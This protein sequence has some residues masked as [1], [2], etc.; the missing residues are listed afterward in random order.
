MTDQTATILFNRIKIRFVL[1]RFLEVLLFAIGL[2]LLVYGAS[3][4]T[5]FS[6]TVRVISSVVAGILFL[7]G[8]VWIKNLFRIDRKSIVQYVSLHYPEL[9]F[10]TDLLIIDDSKLNRL[11]RLQ[12]ERTK[13]TFENIVKSIRVPYSFMRP[14]F[15]VL[16][17]GL[18]AFLLSGI[19][20]KT[21]DQKSTSSIVTDRKADKLPP[22][23][24]D[25]EVTITA[26]AYMQVKRTTQQEPGLQIQEGSNVRWTFNFS[27]SVKA[28]YLIF[29]GSDS[30]SLKKTGGLYTFTK[31]FF[32]SGFY[33][34]GWMNQD[35]NVLTSDYFRIDVQQDAAPII[36]ITN[37]PQF[38]EVEQDDD[39]R[40]NVTTLLKDDW[41]IQDAHIIA[42]ISKG[43]GES[44][45]F[46]E[47]RLV[48]TKPK[49]FSGKNIE[50]SLQ[51]DL[52]KM[53]MEPGDE[54]YFYVVGFDNKQP[55]ANRTRTETHFIVLADTAKIEWAMDDGL[56]V[57]LM[58]EYF[59]SQRQIIIDT[60]KLLREKKAITKQE[61]N[62]RSNEL[63]YDQ[64]L[65]R[66]K[67]GEF[68]GEEFESGIAHE[69]EHHEGEDDHDHDDPLAEYSHKH[70][71]E[72]EHQEVALPDKKEGEKED[73]LAAF[74]HAHDDSETATF[75]EQSIR[76]KLKAALAVMWD[77]ELYL[78]L[79]EPDKSL[80]FQ[81]KALKLLKEISNASRIYVHKVGFDPPPVKEE[82][83]LTG[84]LKDILSMTTKWDTSKKSKFPYTRQA[85]QS[86]E[87][88][89]TENRS[90]VLKE[91]RFIFQN[92]GNEVAPTLLEK[93][94]APLETLTLLKNLSDGTIPQDE[95]TKSLRI[96]RKNL[97]QLLPAESE[98]V[99]M[100]P[101]VVHPLE[102]SF[103]EAIGKSK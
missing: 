78:R 54:L 53:G 34:I 16:I 89:L 36:E 20:R 28:A 9:E 65:L 55:V 91:E 43:S 56:G 87:K 96:L 86:I 100:N 1:A 75:F 51:I 45:K 94:T 59:R 77:A 52:A 17:G 92:S 60:E 93:P 67:Y 6:Q 4:F 84:E 72:E 69:A 14:L 24:K 10:S 49:A 63:G 22:A 90:E 99:Q 76:A 38:L 58:P 71:V 26:P 73:P 80:P 47:E 102:K 64:K 48:F 57:D 88:M 41:G 39:Q 83:R 62:S 37:P 46:R 101:G 40:I 25:F 32:E 95:F 7:I 68:L 70:D 3:V 27:D 82:K 29:S 21:V 30:I 33:Q 13:I 5:G 23:L 98:S 85:I 103:T 8:E 12:K 42:T 74:V 50:A 35:D 19:E 2:G 11:E 79:Y 18:A 61:F 44:V 31:R 15:V 81:Y 66:L 97:I